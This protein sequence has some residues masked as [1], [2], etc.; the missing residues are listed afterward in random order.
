[1][2]RSGLVTALIF[3]SSLSQAQQVNILAKV[4]SE[5]IL[6]ETFIKRY[7]EIRTRSGLA[8]N[9]ANRR[10]VLDELIKDKILLLYARE[11]GVEKAIDTQTEIERIETQELLNRYSELK[12]NPKAVVSDNDLLETYRRINSRIKISHLY[13]SS[14]T[15]IDALYSRL[16][17]GESFE[18]L[19]TGVFNDPVL[20][21]NK[22]SLGY[23]TYEELDPAI[24]DEAFRLM[25]GGISKPVR[26]VYGYSII[27]LDDKKTAPLLTENDFITKKS[28]LYTI[29][30]RRKIQEQYKLFS[31]S[32]RKSLNIKYNLQTLTKLFNSITKRQ[33]II[34][35]DC[36]E[37]FP[38]SDPL[39]PNEVIATTK[40]GNLKSSEFTRMAA[41]TSSKQKSFI[42]TMENLED[43]IGGLIIREKILQEAEKLKIKS[44]E[45][46]REK[47]NLLYDEYLI[48]RV[49]D[50]IAGTAIIS[51]SEEEEFYKQNKDRYLL[52]AQ[53]RL[54]SILLNSD[55]SVQLIQNKLRAGED[56]GGL[57]K[58]YSVQSVTAERSGDMGYFALSELGELA[59]AVEKSSAGEI[60]GP[61][62][63]EGKYLFLKCT[64][65][66][67]AVQLS[68]EDM[69][70]KI[71]DELRGMK[72]EEEI[73][74]L[75]RDYRKKLNISVDYE[76][77]MSVS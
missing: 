37:S 48:K 41:L 23:Y 74:A 59:D 35:A 28:Q 42:R 60:I 66:R 27:R 67:E 20:K 9:L 21:A 11:R 52:P 71:S 30:R 53:W 45:S 64:D 10:K 31:D 55:S 14:R 19:A 73:N 16:R 46:Y 24:E 75:V 1:M 25:I 18:S 63:S 33:Q 8:D 5:T 12:I 43:F 22:G 54:S 49:S 6:A 62:A 34:G 4:G 2:I 39:K 47:A 17:K 61:L 3:V 58:Q 76:K 50:E 36:G 44:S 56:F 68:F 51:T 38:Y 70:E 65:R 13:S 69:R 32:V 77:L 57:A 72:T 26:T 15:G 29:T 40:D 7:S